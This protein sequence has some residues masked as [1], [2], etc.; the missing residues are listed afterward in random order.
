MISEGKLR[1]SP[2]LNGG[3]QEKYWLI[4]DCDPTIGEYYRCLYRNHFHGCRKLLRPSWREHVTVIRN[5]E[6]T[7]N[8]DLW[9]KYDGQIVQFNYTPEVVD[10]EVY[11][12]LE[13]DCE[14]LLDIR[15]EYGLPRDPEFALHLT[16]GSSQPELN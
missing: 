9:L 1:Y 8:Q 12:W 2:T 13:V 3:R 15:E 5:E 11:F 7:K 4:L 16:V 6:P 14:Q 10:N